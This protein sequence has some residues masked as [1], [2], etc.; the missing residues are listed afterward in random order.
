MEAF[1]AVEKYCNIWVINS[2]CEVLVLSNNEKE[3]YSAEDVR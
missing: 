3:V 1:I 2:D